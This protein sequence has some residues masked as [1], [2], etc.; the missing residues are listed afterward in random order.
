MKYD[1]EELRATLE[2]RGARFNNS[3]K[4]IDA[5][6]M[7]AGIV[8]IDTLGKLEYFAGNGYTVLLPEWKHAGYRGLSCG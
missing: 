8:G 5:T 3:D 7:K 2:R 6:R 1:M 4:K